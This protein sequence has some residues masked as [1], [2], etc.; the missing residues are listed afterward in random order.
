[1]AISPEGT[2][3][4][5][6]GRKSWV[7]IP[8][9]TSPEGTA[10]NSPGLQSWATLTG[11]ECFGDQEKPTR[12]ALRATSFDTINGVFY[13]YGLKLAAARQPAR[14]SRAQ[15]TRTP[16]ARYYLDS[17][18]LKLLESVLASLRFG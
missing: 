4:S 5:S 17:T 11:R 10:E 7:C 13:M 2:P 16:A 12:F 9:E 6:P 3:E 8:T 15:Q 18:T 14:L 1:M